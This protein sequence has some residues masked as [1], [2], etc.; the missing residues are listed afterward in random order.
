MSLG[1]GSSGFSQG[2][3]DYWATT[4][5]QYTAVTPP[6]AFSY[7]K[8]IFPF[9]FWRG[10]DGYINTDFNRGVIC[11]TPDIMPWITIN[12]YYVDG[13]SGSDANS[14]LTWALAKATINAAITAANTAAVPYIINIRGGTYY[15]TSGFNGVVPT[16]PC[17]FIGHG[18]VLTGT[19]DNLSY[20]LTS[21]TTY[22][23]TRSNVKRVVQTDVI[24]SDGSYLE[25][26]RQNSL[27][28]CQATPGSWY[29]D[30]VTTYV[31]RSDG[32]TVTTA[33]TRVYLTASVTLEMST[34]GNMYMKNITIE[35]GTNGAIRLQNSATNNF[36]AEDCTFAYPTFAAF[37]NAVTILN[38]RSAS[39]IRCVARGG[40]SDGFNSH[41]QTG[42]QAFVYTQDCLAVT[43]GYPASQDLVSGGTISCNGFTTHDGGKWIGL[44]CSARHNYGANIIPV[45]AGTQMWLMDTLSADS[46]GDVVNG[47]PTPPTDFETDQSTPSLFLDHCCGNSPTSLLALSG[48]LAYRGGVFSGAKT[49]AATY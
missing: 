8:T 13:T 11:L 28:N 10:A 17:A 38:V 7:D 1:L 49:N 32:A 20:T 48:T 41:L 34:G 16:Q 27:V 35:G 6:S 25:L 23:V 19:F 40:Q 15:R 47:G 46:Y 44:R 36:C 14:G 26:T 9:T 43:N 22:Q 39:F 24:D 33:N 4:R 31:N 3:A 21:G 18:R 45:H 42:V 29:T 2:A 30:N 5:G 37:T 12:T